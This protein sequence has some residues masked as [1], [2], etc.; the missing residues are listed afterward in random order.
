MADKGTG[1]LK[2]DEKS[3]EQLTWLAEEVTKFKNPSEWLKIANSYGLQGMKDDSHNVIWKLD[4]LIACYDV[5]IKWGEE[6]LAIINQMMEIMGIADKKVTHI[7]MMEL[8]RVRTRAEKIGYAMECF[9]QTKVRLC[10]MKRMLTEIEKENV[11][12][13][14]LMNT[15]VYDICTTLKELK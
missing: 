15:Y 6:R 13:S 4:Q 14:E 8:R 11:K 5:K 1:T 12:V 3:K 9:R 2:L 10:D 7:E